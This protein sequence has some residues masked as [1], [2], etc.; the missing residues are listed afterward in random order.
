MTDHPDRRGLLSLAVLPLLAALAEPRPASAQGVAPSKGGA[1][2]EHDFDYFFGA[3]TVQHRR[4]KVRLAG[5]NDWETYEGAT[6]CIPL[7]GGAA[8]LNDSIT[9]RGGASYRTLGLRA[10]D[11][12]ARTWADW[13]LD[14]RDPGQIDPPGVGRFVGGV[15]LFLSD[16]TI[17]GRNLKVRGQFSSLSPKVAQWDQAFSPDDGKTWETNY[18]MRY[19]RTG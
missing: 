5:S 8:N 16:E 3:W 4:L 19:T 6:T 11:P 13:S 17:D 9:H 15:G 1:G 14:G 7:L 10:Y 2:P 12:K 18:V